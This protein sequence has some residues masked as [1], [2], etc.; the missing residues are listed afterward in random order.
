MAHENNQHS[1][2]QQRADRLNLLKILS[3][4]R[5]WRLDTTLLV[6]MYKTLVRSVL[7]Y[8]SIV[9][10]S[11]SNEIYGALEVIQNDSLRIIFKKSLLDKISVE[12]LREMAKIESIKDR[13]IR[14]LDRYYE[15]ALVTHNPLIN[16]VFASFKNFKRRDFIDPNEAVKS[17]GTIDLNL[18]NEIRSKNQ[19]SLIKEEKY[20]TTLCRASKIIFDLITDNFTVGSGIT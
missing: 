12:E 5:N 10:S 15:N 9:I 6:K 3:Y 18:F 16:E 7:D 13:H 17:D 20:P 19:S 1:K 11:S 14:L 8:A 4:D 2:E